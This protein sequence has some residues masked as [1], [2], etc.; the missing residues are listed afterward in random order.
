LEF[1]SI[2]ADLCQSI[3]VGMRGTKAAVVCEANFTNDEQWVLRTN[4]GAMN[5]NAVT[6]LTCKMVACRRM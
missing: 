3:N 5:L 1:N 2:H 6:H 4:R